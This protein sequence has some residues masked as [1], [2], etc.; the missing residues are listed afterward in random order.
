LSFR[1]GFKFGLL[2]LIF[3]SPL[4]RLIALEILGSSNSTL[5]ALVGVLSALFVALV[6]V[7]VIT[8]KG[9]KLLTRKLPAE[10]FDEWAAKKKK[11]M[12]LQKK[13][14]GASVA[15]APAG[16]E[17]DPTGAEFRPPPAK[18]VEDISNTLNPLYLNTWVADVVLV[19]PNGELIDAF[20]QRNKMMKKLT[21]NEAVLKADIDSGDERKSKKAQVKLELLQRKTK[22]VRED[23][24]K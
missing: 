7:A 4:V 24:E 11:S 10:E 13:K 21:H 20:N 9:D 17:V 3:L 1:K 2:W 8:Y 19:H 18:P 14:G 12:E 5:A 6:T 15:P 16:G 23:E 22:K